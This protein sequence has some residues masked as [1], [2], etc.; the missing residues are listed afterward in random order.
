MASQKKAKT[1][2]LVGKR[3]AKQKAELIETL[4]KIPVIQIACKKIG[5]S[6]ATY[7]RWYHDDDEFAELSDIAKREG[8]ASINELAQSK[9]IEQIGQ[10]N[11]TAIIFWL[12]SRDPNFKESKRIINE[13]KSHG[14][15]DE[16][17]KHAIDGIFTLF[18]RAARKI[19]KR[20]T[21]NGEEKYSDP[22]AVHFDDEEEN[23][24]SLTESD[25]AA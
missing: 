7:Y 2:D 11:M 6:K 24:G 1:Q 15:I 20:Y 17:A 14:P 12:K 21:D 16:K 9:L 19:D 4:E 13:I 8:T 3:I 5:I 23:R 22:D 18:E 10:S 25:G